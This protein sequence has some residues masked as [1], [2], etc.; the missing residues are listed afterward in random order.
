LRD[1]VA[2]ANE[3][4]LH[5]QRRDIR[6]V[7]DR[8]AGSQM[9]DIDGNRY[10]DAISGTC[11]PSMVG[12]GH[13]A[14]VEAVASQF[15]RLAN[16]FIVHDSVP[17]VDFCAKMAE[18]APSGLTKTF[19]CP[20]G[21]EAIEAALKLAIRATGKAEVLSL[22][23]GY[24]GMSLATMGLSG[25]PALREWFPGGVRWPT[26]HQVPSGDRYRGLG[27]MGSL[28]VSAA[29]QAVEATLDGGSYG[30]VAALLLE[31]VQGPGG[32]TVYDAAF[33]RD[34][35]RICR[36]REILLIVDE[37]QTGLARCGATWA[38]DV[39][40][41][42]PDIL[43]VGKAFGGGF[44]F[45]ALVARSDLV[46]DQLESE[47]WHILTFMNQPLQAAAGLA[48]IDV[49]EEQNLAERAREL[50][51]RARAR[52]DAVADAYEVVGDVRGPGLFIGIDL[53][54]NRET[55]RPATE[56]CREAWGWALEH[57]LITWFGGAGNVL[58]FK[59]PLTTPDDEFEEMLD[60]V[61]RTIEF[62]EQRVQARVP[63]PV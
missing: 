37:I 56:A 4:V 46:D 41:V 24:H 39:Y 60:L 55:K 54:E 30:H 9:W 51:E 58:K 17:V 33:Y 21:G 18:I 5:S 47:P 11:G 3:F 20:G 6:L 34:V 48:V 32:H 23:G 2:E 61:E 57:G 8:A 63:A 15:A 50:G 29:A 31:L 62:V 45:G 40:D 59:P 14:V 35:Q 22:H 28:D 10:L 13:P 36:E 44:P 52:L 49:V 16:A 43:V 1:Y 27:G 53:V 25:L 42:Q 26:F 7:F 38:C 19:L 12:H